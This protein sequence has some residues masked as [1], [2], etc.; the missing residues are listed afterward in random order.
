MKQVLLSAGAVALV[1]AWA[2][3]GVAF[4]GLTQS[5]GRGGTLQIGSADPES[6]FWAD[7]Y[8]GPGFGGGA[9]AFDLGGLAADYRSVH[10]MF[11]GS[12]PSTISGDVRAGVEI[13]Q[14]QSSVASASAFGHAQTQFRVNTPVAFTLTGTAYRFS[15]FSDAIMSGAVFEI[16]LRRNGSP[17]SIAEFR[18]GAGDT[19][20]FD[21]SFSGVL[22]SEPFDRYELVVQATSSAITSPLGLG[23]ARVTADYELTLTPVPAPGFAG[24]AGF[25]LLAAARRRR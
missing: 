17:T 22:D 4:E 5:I 21:F 20:S 16:I 8:Q 11:S 24:F 9:G 13:S 23:Q 12:S 3:A 25:G 2:G 18:L 19:G 15:L 7:E 10:S 6:R 14:S 1:S